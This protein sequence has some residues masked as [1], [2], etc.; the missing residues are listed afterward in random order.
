MTTAIETRSDR[1][2]R[3]GAEGFWIA[4]GQAAVVAGS[5]VLVRALTGAMP[6]A[7]YGKL[8]LGLTIAGL[9]NQMITGG[10]SNALSRFWSIADERG[11]RDNYIAGARRIVGFAFLVV[12]ALGCGL[13]LFLHLAG[14][15]EWTAI[16]IAASALAL[17]SGLNATLNGIQTAARQRK[18]VAFHSAAD[19]WLKIGLSLLFLRA[20]GIG[21]DKA[22]WGYA[23]SAALVSLS[24]IVFLRRLLARRAAQPAAVDAFSQTPRQWINDFWNYAWPFSSWGLFTW[25]QIASDRWALQAYTSAAD[26]GTYAVVYQLGYAPIALASGL[27]TTL[28]GPILYQQA[29]DATDPQRNRRVSQTTWTLA[30]IIIGGSFIGSLIAMVAGDWLFSF[31][32]ASNYRNAAH[33]LPLMV[34]S[35]GLFAAGQTLSLKTHSDMT[36]SRT[37]PIKIGTA[38]LG[39]GLNIL[40]AARYGLPGVVWASLLFSLS[41]CCGI[42]ALILI[43]APRSSP[44][45]SREKHRA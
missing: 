29:G 11:D 21:G 16:A 13:L 26:V 25:A 20:F 40:L 30:A 37:V 18:I 17:S 10:I 6:P 41:Y 19:A 24:Q 3:L 32:V 38:V 9:A 12:I 42:A 22:I 31:M 43:T 7:D 39:M 14:F 33:Y 28:L 5:L 4:L 1:W 36:V 35:S 2:R 23:A 34:A 44:S 15:A 8:A 27:L 45:P